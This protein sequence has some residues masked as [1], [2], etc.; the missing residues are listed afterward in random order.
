MWVDVGRTG[1]RKDAF[2]Q[3]ELEVREQFQQPGSILDKRL[4]GASALGWLLSL[5]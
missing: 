4:V 2:S 1:K 3:G 5:S